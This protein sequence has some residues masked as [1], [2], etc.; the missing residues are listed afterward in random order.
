LS[1]D[2]THNFTARLKSD[3][4]KRA[5]P[6]PQ[7][8]D[9]AQIYDCF[10]AIVLMGME[11]LGLCKRG[12]AGAVNDSGAT[13]VDGRLFLNINGGLLTEGYLHGMNVVAEAVLQIQGRCGARQVANHDVGVVTSGA[14]ADGSAMLLTADLQS[15]RPPAA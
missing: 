1:E 12:E 4:F 9:F 13:A 3:L 2:Y 14:L 8:V 5:G 11:G 10:S 7:E 15:P 6:I